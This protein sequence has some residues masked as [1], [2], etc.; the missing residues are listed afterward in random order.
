MTH[1]VAVVI[2]DGVLP[3][4][5]GLVHQVFEAARDASGQPLYT[6]LTAAVA[7]GPVRTSADFTVFAP[8]GLD[9]LADAD[10]VVVPA[11]KDDDERPD[12]P[13]PVVTAA[14]RKAAD[15]GTRVASVCTGAFVLA[16]AGLLDGRRATTHWHSGDLLRARHPGV[17]VDHGVLYVDEDTVLTSAGEAAG[18]DLCLHLVRRDHGAAV[19][20][21]AARRI[22]VAPHRAGGQAQF[23]VR[24]VPDEA[25][26]STAAARA[27]ALTELDRPIGLRELA[28]RSAMS[29]RTFTRRFREETGLSAGEWL[30]RQRV[31][32]A[33]HLLESTALPVD[34]IARASG[35]GT[36]V[37]LRN[38]FHAALG[39]TP[40]AYR[41]AF[42]GAPAEKEVDGPPGAGGSYRT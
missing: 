31:E 4:E 28:A 36:A 34:Q 15:D 22:V 10:T 14:V 5:L 41:S 7:P 20:N 27:W 24:P 32:R 8:H 1:R 13:D 12:G 21:D 11:A 16:A 29:V 2:R 37:S 3:M 33:R 9:A 23:V 18:I 38:H 35:F 25:D 30:T 17:D 40:S 6:V 26:A 42:R 19:A 39:V